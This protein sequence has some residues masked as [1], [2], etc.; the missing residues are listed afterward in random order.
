MYPYHRFFIF[1]SMILLIFLGHTGIQLTLYVKLVGFS[2]IFHRIFHR[3]VTVCKLT[4]FAQLIPTFSNLNLP[5]IWHF[6]TRDD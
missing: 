5:I 2:V 1:S 6:L 4:I 3:H